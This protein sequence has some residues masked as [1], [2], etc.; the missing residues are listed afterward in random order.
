MIG[1]ETDAVLRMVVSMLVQII[2][3]PPILPSI[4][5]FVAEQK[6]A[7]EVAEVDWLVEP[8]ESAGRQPVRLDGGGK[9]SGGRKVAADGGCILAEWSTAYRACMITWSA[10]E[11]Q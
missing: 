10:A 1:M 9:D 4:S 8:S 3:P 11:N 7:A 6:Y 5:C 2:S